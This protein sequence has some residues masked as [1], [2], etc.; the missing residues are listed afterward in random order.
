MYFTKY[1]TWL[2]YIL[3]YIKFEWQSFTLRAAKEQKKNRKKTPENN[4]ISSPLPTT[5]QNHTVHSSLPSNYITLLDH[6]VPLL[7]IPF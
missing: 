1:V 4:K 5:L 7:N 3:L 2:L 6:K